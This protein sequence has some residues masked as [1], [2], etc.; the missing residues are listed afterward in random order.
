MGVPRSAAMVKRH[1]L[2]GAMWMVGHVHCALAFGVEIVA[3]DGAVYVALKGDVHPEI[4]RMMG[5]SGSA[6]R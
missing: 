1:G 3:A 2:V 4:L 6:F 5:G